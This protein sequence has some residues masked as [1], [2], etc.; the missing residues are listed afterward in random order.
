MPPESLLQ[1][2]TNPKRSLYGYQSLDRFEESLKNP[3]FETT[4]SLSTRFAHD[5][6]N[7]IIDYDNIGKPQTQESSVNRFI[8]NVVSEI[9]KDEKIYAKLN[10]KIFTR[11]SQKYDL[12]RDMREGTKKLIGTDWDIKPEHTAIGQSLTQIIKESGSPY[13]NQLDLEGFK[14]RGERLYGNPKALIFPADDWGPE[15]GQAHFSTAKPDTGAIAYVPKY[16]NQEDMGRVYQ[17]QPMRSLD[18]DTLNLGIG[19][20]YDLLEELGHA[21]QYSGATQQKVDAIHLKA[22]QEA[23]DDMV[24]AWAWQELYSSGEITKEEFD[25]K[26][27]EVGTGRYRDTTKVEGYVHGVLGSKIKDRVSTLLDSVNQVQ[28]ITIE[29]LFQNQQ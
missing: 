2:I 9:K 23:W 21:K 27:G 10:E 19:N 13:I 17:N 28:P 26:K 5:D 12:Q 14:E 6:I 8:Q 1:F 20:L 24:G 29:S 11:R 7:N 15:R 25:A 22:E 16:G 4:Q 18:P 3:Q